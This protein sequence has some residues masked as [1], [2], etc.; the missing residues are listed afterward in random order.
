MKIF[1]TLIVVLLFSASA[2]TQKT[3]DL[4]LRVISPTENDTL[5]SP[6]FSIPYQFELQ[7][8]NLGSENILISDTLFIYSTING[9]TLF[10]HSDMQDSTKYLTYFINEIIVGDTIT[11]KPI[12]Y[13]GILQEGYFNQ[14]FIVYPKNSS[15]PI[16]ESDP[17]NNSDCVTRYYS[18]NYLAVET[19]QGFDFKFWPN[20][21]SNKIHF[22]FKME[23]FHL[24]SL[25]GKEM[26][27]VKMINNTIDVSSISSG[28]Y[29]LKF[30]YHN[31]VY[32]RKFVIE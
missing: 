23:D 29:I 31:R 21:A 10:Q 15:N 25:I 2:F 19:Q 18:S 5:F 24:Y 17:N 7:I 12:G 11:V 3:V 13:I 6:G 32:S 14:C 26:S 4:K 22:N 1:P 27:G 20:P 16:T 30:N 9:D 8:I 28:V